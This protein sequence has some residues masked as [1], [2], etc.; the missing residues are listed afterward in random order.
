MAEREPPQSSIVLYVTEDG[1]TRIESTSPAP[2][3][4]RAT[5]ASFDQRAL[6]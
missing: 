1:R 2:S 4:L 5:I 3:A 6:R